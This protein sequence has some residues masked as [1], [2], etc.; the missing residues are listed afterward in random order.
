MTGN[1]YEG[2]V[3]AKLAN[4][5]RIIYVYVVQGYAFLFI[6]HDAFWFG[7]CTAG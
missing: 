4:M 6:W 1:D 7:V 3:A 2:G 5:P